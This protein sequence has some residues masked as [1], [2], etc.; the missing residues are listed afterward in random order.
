MPPRFASTGPFA[1]CGRV[2]RALD[3]THCVH[4]FG[5]ENRDGKRESVAFMTLLSGEQIRSGTACST[6]FAFALLQLSHPR[7][8]SF[9]PSQ[10][11]GLFPTEDEP[12]AHQFGVV[13]RMS[14]RLL[15]SDQGFSCNCAAT[16]PA[17]VALCKEAMRTT[18]EL[19][20]QNQSVNRSSRPYGAR[21]QSAINVGS[22][23]VLR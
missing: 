5:F 15:K 21:L 18:A 11:R 19:R 12:A 2:C 6:S 17:E 4:C 9:C 8:A 13:M 20:K 16:T 10:I 22:R 23:V 3:A 1:C 7:P 14:E